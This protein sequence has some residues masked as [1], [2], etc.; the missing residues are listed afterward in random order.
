MYIVCICEWREGCVSV[1][2]GEG[3]GGGR[4]REGS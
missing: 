1:C 4:E 2:V 3:E